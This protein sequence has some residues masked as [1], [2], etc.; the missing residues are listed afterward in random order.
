MLA[1][2]LLPAVAPAAE[3]HGHDCR[4]T[5]LVAVVRDSDNSAP[6]L[7]RTKDG[8]LLRTLGTVFVDVR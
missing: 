7:L 3:T 8:R 5:R 1:L 2:S 6:F 4:N